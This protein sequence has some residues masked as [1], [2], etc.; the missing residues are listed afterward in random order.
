MQRNSRDLGFN[1]SKLEVK[2]CSVEYEI[3]IRSS[4]IFA[5]VGGR[6]IWKATEASVEGELRFWYLGEG[7][8]VGKVR[9]CV[10]NLEEMFLSSMEKVMETDRVHS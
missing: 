3:H 4:P 1:L 5:V 2:N 10:E 6:G 9:V 8:S 7:V